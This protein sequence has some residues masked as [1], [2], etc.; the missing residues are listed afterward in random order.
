MY[1]FSSTA[2]ISL[3]LTDLFSAKHTFSCGQ[4]FR[5]EPL[6]DGGWSGIVRGIPARVCD[7]DGLLSIRTPDGHEAM[8]R[9]YFDAD[10]DYAAVRAGFPDDPFL[11]AAS[12]FGAGLRILHQEPWEALCVFLFSQCNNIPRIRAIT[13]RF[14]ALFGAPVEWDGRSFF[15]FPT[16]ERIAAL[17]A[18]DLAPLRAGYR[19]P[20]VYHAAQAICAGE[21]DLDALGG[22][23][24]DTARREIMK[25]RGVGRKVAD[26]FLLFGLHKLDAFPVDTWIKKVAAFHS[27][28]FDR[29][30]SAP[31][32]G[33]LQQ[34][35]FYYA[36]E[37][38]LN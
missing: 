1:N 32:A 34:Y 3:P 19:A 12:E 25:L 6:P 37:N 26:C 35:I 7:D 2:R 20:Y 24:T 8:W 38:G 33:I 10:T 30:L 16:P 17:Q 29:W 21:I 28:N 18:E 13:E 11:H 23:D 36:R 22:L 9:D 4:C 27:G 14:C 5:W 31:Y 15:A